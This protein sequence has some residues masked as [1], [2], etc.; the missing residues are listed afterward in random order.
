MK[1]RTAENILFSKSE[2]K[3]FVDRSEIREQVSGFCSELLCNLDSYFKVVDIYG[4]GGIGKSRL[5]TEL[6]N[7]ISNNLYAVSNK[8]VSV[9]FEIE[10]RQ[11]ILRNLM[12]IRRA[13]DENCTI[14]D[15]ALMSYWDKAGCIEKLDDEFMYRIRSGFLGGLADTVGDVSSSIFPLLPSIP[16]INDIFDCVGILI[17]K[18]QQL[19]VRNWLKDISQLDAQSLIDRMP[20]YLGFDIYRLTAK[21][22]CAL[23]FLCDAY[24]Q[25]TPY[26]ESKEWL[27]DLIVEVHHGLFIITGREKLKWDDPENDIFPYY[28]Q[29]FSEDV[30]IVHIKKYIPNA[31]DDIISEILLS[32]QCVPLFVDM[33]IDVYLRE[34]DTSRLINLAYFKDRDQLTRRF[35][36]HLPERWQSILLA[37]S[38]VGIFSEDIFLYISKELGYPCPLEDYEEII[39]TSLSNYMERTKGLVKLHDVF[40]KHTIK[41]LSFTYKREVWH[42]Y[43][44][45]IWARGAGSFNEDWQGTLL[46]L[47]LNLLHCCNQLQLSPTVQETEWILDIFFCIMDT[48]TFFEPPSPG[49]SEIASL[50][51]IFLFLNA[52][53][54]EKVNTNNT[55]RLLHKIS[56]P[57]HFGRHEKSYSVI[58]WYSKSLLGKYSELYI[59]LAQLEQQMCDA[60]TTYWYYPRIKIYI[61]DY[62][63]MVGKFQA[64]L[65]RLFDLQNAGLSED[66]NFQCSR[67]IGHIYRFNMGLDLAEQTYQ[68]THKQVLSSINSRVYLQTNLCETYCFVKLDQFD[69]LYE[70][71][72]EDA[73]TLGNLKNLGKLY[74]SKAI[75]LAVRGQ[76]DKAYSEVQRSIGV[77]QRDGYQSG[78]LFAYMA[79]AYCDYAKYGIVQTSTQEKI[80]ELLVR[81]E[82]YQYF[83]LPL[84]LMAGKL[85]S[86]EKLRDAYEWLNF[87]QT[88]YQYKRFFAKLRPNRSS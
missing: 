83:R 14:F 18:T 11:Q 32:T 25:S 20:Q 6:K 61:A 71:T 88:V 46:T 55:I 26:S 72:L 8:I 78:E 30:A 51:D 59:S 10:G 4:I 45:F 37:L 74:Y 48:R 84:L 80:E 38:V 79:R 21:S 5:I 75:V 56:D 40:C 33:A 42:C 69:L 58:L 34:A 12:Q 9:T 27:M 53:I 81:N 68:A 31:S 23:V 54:Y 29:A 70:A 87:D 57:S 85:Q 41:V 50:N 52:V 16:S 39:H 77:N 44:K 82:V 3:E 7:E 13:L 76:I 28:L 62:L 73:L 63:F 65:Q 67:A 35:I 66:V 2:A 49:C 19:K 1:Q 43:L 22:P 17:Q 60:D 47:F 64:A 24:Q 36:Y 15:F 86:V